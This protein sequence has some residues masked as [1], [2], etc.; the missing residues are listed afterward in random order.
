MA[1]TDLC[2]FSTRLTQRPSKVVDRGP[3]EPANTWTCMCNTVRPNSF[4]ILAKPLQHNVSARETRARRSRGRVIRRRAPTTL[5][6]PAIRHLVPVD[7]VLFVRPGQTPRRRRARSNAKESSPT[8]CSVIR[9]VATCKL[10]FAPA[11][12]IRRVLLPSIAPLACPALQQT[13]LLLAACLNRSK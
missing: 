9:R 4:P 7:S 3:S 10:R 13:T 8:I 11:L 1:S 5:D 12:L 2:V 6:I